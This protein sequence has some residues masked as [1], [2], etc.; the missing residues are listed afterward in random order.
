MGAYDNPKSLSGMNPTMAAL[1][2]LMKGDQSRGV[3]EA[4][5]LR[6]K[7]AKERQNQ[8][9][10]KQMQNVQGAADVWNLEQMSNLSSAPKT[11]AIDTELQRT[12]NG[13]IDIATQAQIYL[14]TQF[15]D[16]EKRLSAQKAIK[17]YYDLLDLTKK[18]V[19]SFAATGEYWKQNAATIGKKITI[20]GK[21]QNEIA[22]NQFFLNSIGDVVDGQF[23]MV[24]DPESND[25]MVKVSGYETGVEDGKTVQGDYRE[26]IISARKWNAQVNEGSNFDFV[27]NVPQVVN[28]SLDMMKT[29]EQS[30]NGNGIGVI[31]NN[32]QIDPRFWTEDTI[33]Y[34]TIKVEGNEEN[35]QKTTEI[36]NYLNM[37][38]LRNEMEGIL[39]QKISGVNTNVQTAANAWNIDLQ[40]LNQGFENDYQTINP[41]DD[42]FK[43]ALFEQIVKANTSNLKQDSE[44]RW[45][46]SRNK[47]IVKLADP[48][49]GPGYRAEYYNNIMN[50]AMDNSQQTNMQV[51]SDNMNRISPGTTL[52]DRDEII[53]LWLTQP[54]DQL[55]SVTNQEYY[56]RSKIKKQNNGK[57]ARSFAEDLYGKE[58]FYKVKGNSISFAGN[59]NLE[60]AVDRLKFALDNSTSAERK[61]ITNKTIL[62]DRAKKTDWMKANP[63]GATNAEETEEEYIKRMNKALNIK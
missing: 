47:A 48:I 55:S 54:N 6:E 23:E 50:G 60:S 33:V 9:V 44:G 22:N 25:I 32:G 29:K 61:S 42:Q 12:L 18:T 41:T 37:E 4:Q 56:D 30:K 14:K 2:V 16:N 35:A 7:Q 62:M 28:E 31:A 17:D 27:S 21:D 49:E 11:S 20:L 40:K 24:Y 10:I 3:D 15:G 39:T 52:M 26:K 36:R 19:T 34:D 58:G 53:D 38:S 59:Y 5:R 43:D 51:V 57:G 13:R 63:M 1:S 46:K 45:Y 8:A